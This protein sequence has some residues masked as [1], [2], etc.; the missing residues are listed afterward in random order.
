[1][2]A[3]QLQ[4]IYQQLKPILPDIEKLVPDRAS[5]LRS[6]M[7]EF[8]QSMEGRQ[9]SM[10][11]KFEEITRTGTTEEILE[12]ARNAPQGYADGLLQQAAFKAINQG[13]ESQAR[14]IVESISDPR[15]RYGMNV[16]LARQGYHR[17]IEQKKVAEARALASRLPIEEQV[18][19]LTQ[20]AN[21]TAAEGDK[22]A[23]IQLLAEAQALLPIRA[24]SYSLLQAQI[25]IAGA[26]EQLDPS[27][28]A[29]IVE[30]VIDQTND[31]AAAALVLNGFD[32]SGYFRD[33][34][35]VINNGNPLNQIAESCG[36][37][38]GA[39]ARGDLDRARVAA[40]RFQR[41][42]MRLMALMQIAQVSTTI[43]PNS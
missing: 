20:M 23:A 43:E 22:V 21:S 26:Y 17:A 37:E 33:G 27:R 40:E 12:A 30:R 15:Q 13:D 6:K 7:A 39:V 11:T 32:V 38:L 4:G 3:G 10:W 29:P 16:Q 28:S 19:L 41:P 5:A 18:S 34:E 31:L 35:F 8:E 14:Q 36:R 25:M 24:T 9:T 42:E 2:Y 1:L